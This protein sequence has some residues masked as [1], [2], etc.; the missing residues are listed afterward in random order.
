MAKT[1]EEKREISNRVNDI[2]KLEA[3]D[4]VNKLNECFINFNLNDLGIKVN[5]R[6]D[7]EIG[8][9]GSAFSCEKY[10]K[11]RNEGRLAER[12]LIKNDFFDNLMFHESRL[13]LSDRC[14]TRSGKLL[15][16]E[17]VISDTQLEDLIDEYIG[18]LEAFSEYIGYDMKIG[19]TSGT[20]VYFR[21]NKVIM[22]RVENYV[23]NLTKRQLV[24]LLDSFNTTQSEIDIARVSTKVNIVA[25]IMKNH[26]EA[27]DK[28]LSDSTDNMINNN[29]K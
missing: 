19:G 2:I 28:K 1:K 24:V 20:Y 29:L 25:Y 13:S 21:K 5:R 14:L 23:N 16:G 6:T 4:F 10:E 22:N 3:L 7:I 11:Y 12:H 8:Y 27:V 17:R 26:L 15:Y 18:C 9:F